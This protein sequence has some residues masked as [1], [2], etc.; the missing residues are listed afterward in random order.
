MV[1]ARLGFAG[2]TGFALG[3]VR[4]NPLRVAC[5]G[6]RAR[7]SLVLAAM[8]AFA[9]VGA[10][11]AAG[12]RVPR[13]EALAA[14][15]PGVYLDPEIAAGYTK[16]QAQLAPFGQFEP[17]SRYG[18][19]FCPA[20]SPGAEA[21]RPYATHG[22]WAAGP[23]AAEPAQG[24][25]DANSPFWVADPGDVM[26]EI[27]THHGWW[28]RSERGAPVNADWCW[29]PGTEETPARVVWTQSG[30]IV[31]YA[32]SPP[33]FLASYGYSQL[34]VDF[35]Y[36]LLGALFEADPMAYCLCEGEERALA[37]QLATEPIRERFPERGPTSSVVAAARKTL[38]DFQQAHTQRFAD[39][40][41]ALRA[42]SP[43][44]EGSGDVHST[45]INQLTVK[46]E[47][48]ALAASTPSAL[49][50]EAPPKSPTK[51]SKT[52]IELAQREPLPSLLLLRD[53]LEVEQ[54]PLFSPYA[55]RFVHMDPQLRGAESATGAS[56]TAS[57][58]SRSTSGLS[59]TGESSTQ[60]LEFVGGR[61]P[62]ARKARG[63]LAG[64][65]APAPPRWSVE[66]SAA[67][68][69]LTTPGARAP[70]RASEPVRPS[71]G[72]TRAFPSSPPPAYAASAAQA[73]RAASTPAST[74]A[75]A[76]AVRTST[77]T[78]SVKSSASTSVSAAN[79][80][81]K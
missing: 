42:A 44:P 60:A 22:H 72:A 11:C 43:V 51:K 66:N 6:S 19:R 23:T 31:G 10:G 5:V 54:M 71:Q 9:A 81:R 1:A 78:S 75:S 7:N 73:P 32:P 21:F 67:A 62:S 25:S 37:A 30:G 69:A 74:S 16:Y 59:G 2:E 41:N 15:S 63:F 80:S 76:A 68:S 28:V 17:D 57:E 26:A 14:A 46:N 13:S 64:T 47:P 8:S 36:L 56:A 53:V 20:P 34:E 35:T 40:R 48:A 29:V 45:K 3:M 79:K 77:S 50:T 12:P 4:F 39:R 58:R 49:A 38:T 52:A 18:V 61:A 33:Q 55:L 65:Q 24:S 27:T 70:S